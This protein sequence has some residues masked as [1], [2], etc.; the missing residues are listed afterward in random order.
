MLHRHTLG[1]VPPKPH[2]ALYDENGKLLM[3]QMI[4]REGFNGPFSILYYRTPPTD[5][6]DVTELKLTGFCPV[7]L[8]KEQPLHRRLINTGDIAA[9]G[10]YLTGRRTLLVNR[11]LHVSVAKP[12]EPAG[13]FFSNG[14]GDELYF[15]TRGSGRLV[16]PNGQADQGKLASSR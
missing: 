16:P 5:E 9:G 14:D 6:F 10:D 15:V 1:R 8:V 12:A 2:T 13:R 7:E 4:T 3:E 11:N